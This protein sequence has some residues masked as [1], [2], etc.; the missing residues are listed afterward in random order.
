MQK[1]YTYYYY[2]VW[3]TYKHTYLRTCKYHSSTPHTLPPS[4]PHT[5]SHPPTL[6]PPPPRWIEA[7]IEEEIPQ[8][9]ELEEAL[10]NGVILCKLGHYYAPEVVPLRRIYDIQE[11]KYRVSGVCMCGGGG[12][13][14]ESVCLCD[15]Q[16]TSTA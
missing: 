13:G 3:C 12:G 4:H 14:G 8:S 7:C 10:R 9:T 16:E 15:I 5:P 2:Y 6:T 11:T 1:M